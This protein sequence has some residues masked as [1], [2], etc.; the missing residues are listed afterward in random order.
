MVVDFKSTADFQ[1][2]H[3]ALFCFVYLVKYQDRSSGF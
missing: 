1:K 3:R 2:S